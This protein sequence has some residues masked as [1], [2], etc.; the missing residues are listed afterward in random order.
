MVLVIQRKRF[1]VLIFFKSFFSISGDSFANNHENRLLAPGEKEIS[2]QN[3][4][5]K[6]FSYCSTGCFSYTCFFPVYSLHWKK[7]ILTSRSQ[8]KHLCCI[9]LL[10]TKC[11]TLLLTTSLLWYPFILFISWD[12][13]SWAQTPFVSSAC[14]SSFHPSSLYIQCGNSNILKIHYYNSLTSNKGKHL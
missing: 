9:I 14:L 4:F 1:G 6:F 5:F 8:Q 11:C 3:S 10:M 12:K 13:L 7:I 2:S